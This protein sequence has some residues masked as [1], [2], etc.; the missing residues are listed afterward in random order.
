M[1]ELL[2]KM[3]TRFGRGAKRSR[4]ILSIFTLD[5]SLMQTKI[6]WTFLCLWG[7]LFS[8]KILIYCGGGVRWSVEILVIAE[9]DLGLMI[10]IFPSYRTHQSDGHTLLDRPLMSCNWF[11]PKRPRVKKPIFDVVAISNNTEGA[12]MIK[13]N[14][15]WIFN[16]WVQITIGT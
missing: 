7:K 10:I 14:T 4:P 13:M 2:F 6:G 1:C 5:L 12:K 9:L 3:L 8:V 11:R 15:N 16:F